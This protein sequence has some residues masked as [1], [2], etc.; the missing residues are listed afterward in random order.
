ME[1]LRAELDER[2]ATGELDPAVWLPY[3][4]P[5]WATRAGSAATWGIG[6]DGLVLRIPAEQPLWAPDQHPE[7]LRV[8]CIQSGE[9]DGQQP[10]LAM[11]QVREPQPTFWG[12]TPHHGHVEVR[13]RMRISPRSM[14]AF[15][16]SG[17]ERTRAESGEICVAEIFG[18]ALVTGPDGPTAAVG[19]GV[20]AFADPLL[21]QDFEAVRMRLDVAAFHTYAVDWAPGALRFTIDGV[22]V[23]SLAQSPDYPVQLMIGVFDFPAKAAADDVVEPELVVAHVRATPLP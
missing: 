4:L 10:F 15:W 17:L 8:S 13:M 16:M 1:P 6:A 2:F 18:D 14:A 3:Y 20:K 9:H 11:Q 23:R 12:C 5:H 21:T 19:V 7:P 22:E